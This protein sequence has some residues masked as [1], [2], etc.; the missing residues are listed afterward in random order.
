VDRINFDFYFVLVVLLDTLRIPDEVDG[1]SKSAEQFCLHLRIIIY[2]TSFTTK[3]A[4]SNA[5]FLRC[6]GSPAPMS[7]FFRKKFQAA[8]FFTSSGISLFSLT[9]A[10]F[11]FAYKSTA[12][13]KLRKMAAVCLLS[14]VET[15]VI[16]FP[17]E[18]RVL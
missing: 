8:A 16:K 18:A 1:K 13:M 7:G 5:F 6:T 4:R 11:F 9:S 12:R 17:V 10:Q 3:N 15:Y 14:T 2:C